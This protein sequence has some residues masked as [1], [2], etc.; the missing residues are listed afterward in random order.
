MIAT[1]PARAEDHAAIAGLLVAAFA[2][3]AEAALVAH[4]RSDRVTVAE[5]VV[6]SGGQ[7]VSHALCSW[8]QAPQGWVALAPV[9]TQP[10]RQGQ[11]FGS[12]AVRGVL[13]AARAAGARAAVV[14]GAP[15]FYGRF[16]FSGAQASGLRS[17]YPIG[18]TA[19]HDFGLALTESE[20]GA[21]LIYPAAFRLI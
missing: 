5:V 2:S 15:E 19:V 9:A 8:M 6:T 1:R 13:D 10:G 21:E 16:G 4:L 11:G 17:P 18:F 3:P 7:I 20:R 12:L 14:L